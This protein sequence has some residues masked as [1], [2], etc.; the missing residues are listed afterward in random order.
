MRTDVWSRDLITNL[1][2]LVFLG[3]YA[4]TIHYFKMKLTR[5]AFRLYVRYKS[6]SSELFKP[7][8]ETDLSD[9][10]SWT[11]TKIAEH[12][13]WLN[14][15]YVRNMICSAARQRFR[16]CYIPESERDEPHELAIRSAETNCSTYTRMNLDFRRALA[17]SRHFGTEIETDSDNNIP[18]ASLPTSTPSKRREK[19]L[20]S[21]EDELLTEQWKTSLQERL[22]KE[23]EAELLVT[24]LYAR[25]EKH[26]VSLK[27]K[28]HETILVMSNLLR[29]LAPNTAIEW[30]WEDKAAIEILSKVSKTDDELRGLVARATVQHRQSLKLLTDTRNL[31]RFKLT[32]FVD[33]TVR[34]IRELT[35]ILFVI[36]DLHPNC[37]DGRNIFDLADVAAHRNAVLDYMRGKC[38]PE[39][40]FRKS[41]PVQMFSSG[42]ATLAEC[43]VRSV[44]GLVPATSTTS[45][46]TSATAYKNTLRAFKAVC[47]RLV[48]GR[49]N[50]K[51]VE[52]NM[53]TFVRAMDGT[54]NIPL[55]LVHPAKF[56]HDVNSVPSPSSLASTLELFRVSD[57][58]TGFLIQEICEL[59]HMAW[60]LFDLQYFHHY[61][62]ATRTCSIPKACV[63]TNPFEDDNNNAVRQVTQLLRANPERFR[64]SGQPTILVN[65]SPS[66]SGK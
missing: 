20:E 46:R 23:T 14:D 40:L 38:L 64:R 1:P 24:E 25:A 19:C 47:K 5:T 3:S 6:R 43:V 58:S 65:L 11:T 12:Q 63:T 28:E 54:L 10:G 51:H 60:L 36:A 59:N 31:N 8:P 35:V 44:S 13:D 56:L 17:L 32:N 61:E 55:A 48:P 2:R 41:V 53:K 42:K 4:N 29:L 33:P 49:Y 7:I 15:G 66:P 62:D 39:I 57:N 18:L 50:T 26:L 37:L 34:K 52:L 45:A 21:N 16:D 22:N 27:V 9:V 30:S